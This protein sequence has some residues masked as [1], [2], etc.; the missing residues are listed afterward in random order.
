MTTKR[1]FA[2]IAKTE[3]QPDGTIKVWGYAST[4]A[5]DSD[6]ETVTPDAMK[7]AL[8]DY[9][10]FGAVRE[11]HDSK[12]AA[13]TA[14]EAKV[15]DDGKTW[16][17]A[18][19]VDSEAVK[20]V[21]TGVYKGFSIG[22]K[23]TARDELNKSVI[24]GIK[25]IE[26]SLV[27]RPANPEAV[28]TVMKAEATPQDD[29]E[30]LADMLDAGTITPRQ[31][32][33]LA[34]AAKEQ[35][36]GTPAA[37]VAPVTATETVAKGMYTVADLAQTLS[38]IMWMVQSTADETAWEGDNSPIAAKL[39]DW[40]SAGGEIL[41]EMVAEEVAEMT[42]DGIALAAQA[43]QLVKAKDG[44]DLSKVGAAL[45][46]KNK[47]H[48][49]AIHKACVALGACASTDKAAHGDDMAKAQKAHA[50]MLAAIAKAAGV[51]EGQS[52]T[53][54]VD[55]LVKRA[56]TAEESLTKAQARVTQL[57]A[58]PAPGKALLKAVAKGDD[59]GTGEAKPAVDPVKKSDGTVDDTA[60]LI[61]AI[62]AGQPLA[63]SSN[64]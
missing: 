47:A 27:D 13:G 1:F 14:I 42:G 44:E 63:G 59:L 48:V 9:M 10:K 38:N 16:F 60:T 29:V 5:K 32:I 37:V 4:G 3:D 23:V 26:V 34:K 19:V 39:K 45:S 30:E 22:G 54:A 31:L 36:A 18:H 64:P 2:E 55:A 61:K 33:E 28:I 62:H 11:M 41:K 43:V 49:D 51:A 6:D 15:E 56:T 50:D 21:Q 7:A 46:A 35:P 40:L 25:L 12:K 17:G 57:E 20:K 8:P 58:M 52:V 24:K 53:D